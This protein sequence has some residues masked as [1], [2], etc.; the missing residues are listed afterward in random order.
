MNSIFAIWLMVAPSSVLQDREVKEYLYYSNIDN[1]AR[2]G[3]QEN[4]EQQ[5]RRQQG[6]DVVVGDE[7]VR[8]LGHRDHQNDHAGGTD[9]RAQNESAIVEA[10]VNIERE[11]GV[12]CRRHGV[13][14][15]L[16]R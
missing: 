1:E 8:M 16:D 5:P 9:A 10:V 12:R 14:P 15:N 4:A 6:R 2:R 11:A 13:I 3:K 7:V